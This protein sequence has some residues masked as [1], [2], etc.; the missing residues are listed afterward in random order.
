MTGFEHALPQIRH[1]VAWRRMAWKRDKWLVF[2][3]ATMEMKSFIAL[4]Y[5][6]GRL[7]PNAPWTPTRCD[8]MEMDWERVDG[9]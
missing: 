3:P 8:L 4:H 5:T 1:G 7:S 2:V 6:D 9:S